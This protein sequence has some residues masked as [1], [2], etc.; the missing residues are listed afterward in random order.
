MLTRDELKILCLIPA[1]SGS[2]TV[3]HKNVR[4][5][6]GI[7]LIAHTIL[8][9][10]ESKYKPRM[11]VIVSTDSS[12]YADIAKS[13]GAE[14]PFLRPPEIS[15]PTSTDYE[16]ISH[17]V[18]WLESNEKYRP[19]IILQLRPTQPHRKVHDIDRCIDIF[20]E[21]RHSYDSLRTV[22]EFE[23]SPFK[24]YTVTESNS[25][26]P[27]LEPLFR[28]L[29]GMTEP[30][31]QARQVLPKAYLHNGYIDILNTKVLSLGA[32]SGEKIFPYVMSSLDV[33]DIDTEEDWRCAEMACSKT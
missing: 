25:A 18:N 29:N 26:N 7:P 3:Q 21:K 22:V 6:N 23:K 14:C 33:I 10:L 19:D 20:L 4:I 16:C 11:R 2:I 12:E 30:F 5:F 32:L 31:N 9:A 28:T 24:M 15:G 17:C 27:E 1:R 8:Q 13:W